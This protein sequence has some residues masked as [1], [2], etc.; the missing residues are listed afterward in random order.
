MNGEAATLRLT[1]RSFANVFT[2]VVVVV[3]VSVVKVLVDDDLLH[4]KPLLHVGFAL[5]PSVFPQDDRGTA[6]VPM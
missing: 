3:S 6:C 4:S 1:C 5:I 2:D